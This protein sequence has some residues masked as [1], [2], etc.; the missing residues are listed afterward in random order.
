M[1]TGLVSSDP[2]L[3]VRTARGSHECYGGDKWWRSKLCMG[4]IRK[5]SIYVAKID[6]AV[7]AG[8]WR[9]TGDKRRYCAHCALVALAPVTVGKV[10]A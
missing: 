10:A 1:A 9:W 5:G 6:R 8:K 4:R 2:T 7:I 3:Q